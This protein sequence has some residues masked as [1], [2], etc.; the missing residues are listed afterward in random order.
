M[1][2]EYDPASSGSD[3]DSEVEDAPNYPSTFD[4]LPTDESDASDEDSDGDSEGESDD[5][6]SSDSDSDSG[7]DPDTANMSLAERLAASQE[8]GR[9]AVKKDGK[10]KKRSLKSMLGSEKDEIT[11]TSP[12][13]K[14]PSSK[15]EKMKKKSK[16]APT[17]VSSSRKAYFERGAPQMNNNGTKSFGANMFKGS[18]DPRFN[19]MSGNMNVD[20]FEKG[21]KFLEE[22]EENEIKALKEKIKAGQV[23]G[24]KGQKARK[25]LGTSVDDLPAQQEELKRLLNNR[26]E[27]IRSQV[28]RS[29]KRAVKKKLRANVENGGK[30]YFLK[31]RDMR[32]EIVEAKFEELR[33]RGGDKAVKKA[34]EKRRKKNSNKDHLKMPTVRK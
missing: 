31:K 21:Y 4:E 33:K 18:V 25:R 32:K 19:S 11:L 26:G 17:E 15:D 16:H 10:N 27:R 3:N 20:G 6:D 12:T 23:K 28:E 24:K 29:A 30:A 14:K 1:A 5:K 7:A 13:S 8:R 9:V 34:I 2:L 22:V